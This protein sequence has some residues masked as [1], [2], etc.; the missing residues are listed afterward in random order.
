MVLAWAC[1]SAQVCQTIQGVP[2]PL[3]SGRRGPADVQEESPAF[4]STNHESMRLLQLSQPSRG[5]PV[6]AMRP[7]TDAL[8][9]HSLSRTRSLQQHREPRA[10]PAARPSV[11]SLN[12][13]PPSRAMKSNTVGITTPFAVRQA[14]EPPRQASVAGG[15]ASPG[16]GT[17]R[18]VL[19]L[20]PRPRVDAHSP[21]QA[22]P[23]ARPPRRGARVS[24]AAAPRNRGPQA[25][26]S[27]VALPMLLARRPPSPARFEP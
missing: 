21:W 2:S 16:S 25:R 20:C 18:H 22:H 9:A 4:L 24:P 1:F 5:G 23:Q 10:A 8:L 15:A 3:D 13:S 27:P 26:P 17:A 12:P 14:V 19:A 7:E 11:L 6:L